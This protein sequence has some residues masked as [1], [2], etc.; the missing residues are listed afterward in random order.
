MFI[1]DQDFNLIKIKEITSIIEDKPVLALD[2]DGVI[3]SPYAL[4]T[5]YLRERGYDLTEEQSSAISCVKLNVNKEDHEYA[6]RKAFMTEPKDLPLEKG[7]IENYIKIRKMNIAIFI[8]TSR[9]DDMLKHL[10]SY[11]AY[12]K[13]KV[14]GVV[15]TEKRSKTKALETIN[16]RF[17]VDDTSFNLWQ[18]IQEDKEFAKKCTLV[19]YRN[20]QNKTEKKPNSI[21]I[22]AR[23]WKDVYSIIEDRFIDTNI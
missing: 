12:Y 11:L 16:A 23:N 13:I 1:Q 4:N 17:F 22:E 3:T 21:V 6:T 19:L 7:F 2:F 9:T 14:E 10:E 20:V 18:V 15:N 5:H 8:V